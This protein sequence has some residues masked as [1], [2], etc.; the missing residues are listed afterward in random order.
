MGW[1]KVVPEL[2]TTTGPERNCRRVESLHV[3]NI[4][5]AKQHFFLI[6]VSTSAARELRQR[7]I[8]KSEPASPVHECQGEIIFIHL[9]NRTEVLQRKICIA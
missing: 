3:S 6:L 7:T 8:E 1:E 4:S 9:E 5:L 2:R